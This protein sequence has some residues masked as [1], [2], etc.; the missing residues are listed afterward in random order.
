MHSVEASHFLWIINKELLELPCFILKTAENF[1][2]CPVSFYRL[3]IEGNR[4]KP[5]PASARPTTGETSAAKS[6]T[7]E[8][9]AT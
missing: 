7:A 1:Y 3:F 2:S 8:S 5:L 4:I 9:A 6:T